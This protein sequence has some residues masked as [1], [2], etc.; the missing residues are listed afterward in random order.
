M[1]LRYIQYC[2]LYNIMYKFKWIYFKCCLCLWHQ[3]LCLWGW[4]K[5]FRGPDNWPL[6]RRGKM[7]TKFYLMVTWH[8]KLLWFL[9]ISQNSLTKKLG[10]Q[11]HFIKMVMVVELVIRLWTM[12]GFA[13]N[14]TLTLQ[15]S[16]SKKL[17]FMNNLSRVIP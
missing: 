2:M 15:S 10:I 6:Q 5:S 16:T 7:N 1:T 17:I 14:Y 12:K 8:L 9:A 4:M 13:Y 3:S 11:Y